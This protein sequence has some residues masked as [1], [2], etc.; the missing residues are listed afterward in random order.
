MTDTQ[1]IVLKLI[2]EAMLDKDEK[3]VKGPEKEVQY[4][5]DDCI[6]L[7]SLL[8]RYDSKKHPGSMKLVKALLSIKD[9][10]ELAWRKDLTEVNLT[11]EEASKLKEYL[12]N[13]PDLEGKEDSLRQFELR[14]LVAVLEALE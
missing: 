6:G 12:T 10:M 3:E 2:K 9:K 7:I 14:T 13:L 5:R 8:N 11:L 4:K 1:K